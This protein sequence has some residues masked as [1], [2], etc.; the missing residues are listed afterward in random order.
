MDLYGTEHWSTDHL[1]HLTDIPVPRE[2]LDN[3]KIK[4]ETARIF[5]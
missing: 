1:Y 3:F 2:H 5:I 4:Y